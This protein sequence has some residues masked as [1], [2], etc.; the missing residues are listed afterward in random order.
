MYDGYKIVVC[1]PAGR[2]RTL[3]LLVNHLRAQRGLV[4]GV[5]LW[6]NTKDSSDAQ[7]IKSLDGDDG[8]FKVMYL[9][10]C[11][12]FRKPL[13]K[14]TGRFYLNCCDENTIYVRLDDDM[15]YLHEDAIKNLIIHRLAHPESFVVFPTIINNAISSHYLQQAGKIGTEF[16]IAGR[17]CMDKVGWGDGNFAVYLHEM[18]IDKIRNDTVE[19]LYM[20]DVF[21]PDVLRISVSGFAWFGK[22]FGA[23]HHNV[24]G[25]YGNIATSLW[26]SEEENWITGRGP[27]TIDKTSSICG[28]S[29]LSHFSFYTQHAQLG[30]TDL[31]DRYSNISMD[32]L[33][34][35]YYAFI[36]LHNE[37]PE[38]YTPLQWWEQVPSPMMT[39]LGTSPVSAMDMEDKTT[40]FRTPE[41]RPVPQGENERNADHARRRFR[42]PD[43]F[44]SQMAKSWRERN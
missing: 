3:S 16:G 35:Q 19:D 32:K 27:M 6:Y 9:D 37:P 2:E 42:R 31:L 29:I 22:D 20:P 41:E 26:Y 11:E 17:H 4:D 40:A 18:L 10:D 28:N 33:H 30:K 38:P 23:T 12:P 1:I 36:D 7:Y 8:Y 25:I 14:N 24:D 43:W 34:D 13:Q 44:H 39:D 21:L 15:V 5:Q